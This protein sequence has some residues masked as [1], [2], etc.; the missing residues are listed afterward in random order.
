MR[1]AG[2]LFMWWFTRRARTPRWIR[3]T[4]A[5]I[6]AA[7]TLISIADPASSPALN[8]K[9]HP[10]LTEPSGIPHVSATTGPLKSLGGP[11]TTLPNAPRKSP[12][13]QPPGAPTKSFPTS[14]QLV[15]QGETLFEQG[16]AV[17]HG[18][19][20]QGIKNTAP[21]LIGVGAGPV[22]FY[23]STGRMPLDHPRNEPQRNQVAYS[24][25]QMNAIIAFITKVGGGPPAPTAQPAKGD[26]STGFHVF[27]MYCGGCHQEVARGGLVVGAYTP[28]LQKATAQQVAEAVR[29]GPYLM[30]HFDAKQINQY[31][32]DSLAKY[33][34][35]TRKPSDVGGWGIYNIGPIPEG[36]VAWFIGLLAI[37][38]VARLIGE[39]METR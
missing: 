27:D 11:P 36:L 5:L 30:P 37:V 12:E 16:C 21:S 34:L 7:I 23:L 4:I 14:P 32:L 15:A 26:L 33:V 18:T 2:R 29:M 28:N 39:R 10:S 22:D 8:S 24:R 6:L 19:L 17:C 25:E 13:P 35:W 9:R 31:Q 3:A 1:A 38:F 20:L